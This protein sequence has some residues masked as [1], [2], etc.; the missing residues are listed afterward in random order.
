M[1]KRPSSEFSWHHLFRGSV[2]ESLAATNCVARIG[3][4][5]T[6]AWEGPI[7][8]VVDD[9]Q[10]N[11][12]VVEFRPD[13]AVG[14][15]SAHT[16]V[17]PFDRVRAVAVAPARWQV[18]LEQICRLPLLSEGAGISA[19][20]WTAGEFIQGPAPESWVNV[21]AELFR[22]ELLADSV[23][24][25]EA[26]A[27]YD[28]APDVA[29]LAIAIAA[30]AVVRVPIVALPESELRLLVPKGSKHEEQALDL[31][32]SDGLFEMSPAAAG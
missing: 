20:L 12:G 10:G 25:E 29:R 31:L 27:Y 17:R 15:I 8:Y 2:R 14:A 5:E 3:I 19:V 26:R 9:N 30:R 4:Q 7:R 22:R 32:T 21:G 6:R 1:S 23:W 16:P 11:V 24:E 18:A 13:G 28:L